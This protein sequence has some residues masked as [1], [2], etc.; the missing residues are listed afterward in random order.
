ME[1][2]AFRKLRSQLQQKK[3]FSVRTLVDASCGRTVLTR[4]L[5]IAKSS[6]QRSS[7]REKLTSLG[8]MDLSKFTFNNLNTIY[9]TR[10]WLITTNA[11]KQSLSSRIVVICFSYSPLLELWDSFGYLC[12]PTFSAFK[13]FDVWTLAWGKCFFLQA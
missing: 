8:K 13:S 6:L 9:T 3:F 4:V 12:L 11:L 2:L 5:W 10:S 1:R 7:C